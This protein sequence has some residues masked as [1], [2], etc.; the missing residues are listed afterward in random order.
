MRIISGSIVNYLKSWLGEDFDNNRPNMVF[1]AWTGFF[2]HPIYYFLC[3]KLLT[4]FED[5]LFFRFGSALLCLPVLLEKW[6]PSVLRPWLGIY[7]YCSIIFILPISFT[8]LLLLNNFSGMWLVCEVTMIFF[9]MIL[10][11]HFGLVFFILGVGIPLGYF[12]F[13]LYGGQNIIWGHQHLSYIVPIPVA[14]WSGVIFINNAQKSAIL[15]EKTKGFVALAGSIA[16]EMRN[17]L[18]QIKFSLD[19]IEH[20]LP[21]PTFQKGDQTLPNQHLNRLYSHL[22]Q[23]QVA[24]KR[25]L[26]VI[27]MTLNEV[28]GKPIAPESLE[29]LDA[30]KATQK[31]I[32]EY[33]FD[34]EGERKK[35]LLQVQSNFTF[36]VNETAYV[37]VLFNLIKNALYHLKSKPE[38]GITITVQGSRITVRDTGPGIAPDVL[39]KLFGNFVSTNTTG[40]TGLGLAYC[41]RTMQAFGGSIACDSVLGQYT[42]FTLQFPPL[43]PEAIDAYEQQVLHSAQAA[44]H[45]KRI[46]V[47]DDQDTMRKSTRAMLQGLD[48]QLD[49]AENGQL[50][51]EKLRHAPYDLIV[52]DLNMPPLDGYAAAEAIRQGAVPSQKNIPILAYTAE[53]AYVAHVKTQKVGMNGFVS[54]PCSRTELLKALY[55]A[56]EAAQANA[57]TVDLTVLQGKTIVV[58]DDEEANRKIVKAY[59]E[60]AGSLVLEATYG[61]DVLE[62]LEA[63]TRVHAVLMD[64]HMP[65]MGGVQVTRL[66]RA[67]NGRKHIP[68]IALTANFTDNHV[69]EALEAG[70]NDFIS[71]PIDKKQ[72]LEKLALLL[73]D[74]KHERPGTSNALYVVP[75]V[76][77]AAQPA[78]PAPTVAVP[79]DSAAQT[80][81][82]QQPT[83]PQT[84]ETATAGPGVMYPQRGSA[85]PPPNFPPWTPEQ[86]AHLQATAASG[87]ALLAVERLEDMRKI[88]LELMKEC[89]DGYTAK[90]VTQFASMRQQMASKQDFEG[91]SFTLHSMVGNAGEAGLHALHQYLR[92]RVYA[93]VAQDHQWP[94]EENWIDTAQDLYTQSMVAMKAT[95]LLGYV[96]PV[97]TA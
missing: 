28:G 35:V 68:V 84:T 64:M 1:S 61:T 14:L 80:E 81:V 38:A 88:D 27:A 23:G 9:T 70:M 77:I 25:G 6:L 11:G 32:E 86:L 54:K 30:A 34:T 82:A 7:W 58:A 37:F 16:H 46:L 13:F 91:F 4:G 41:Q 94:I 44:L 59:L 76:A 53:S 74:R 95:Y 51:I 36:K 5:S 52:M 69:Q 43:A 22:A 96:A 12:C 71:K 42:E 47:V 72:M 17:P 18:G 73:L 55:T 20:T 57:Q 3:T 56:V 45:G 2:A 97:E 87:L 85:P 92:Y 21:S 65:V 29:Y 26:Q 83:K 48:A 24:I 79:T 90:M 50:A 8:F 10:V 89:I 19:S 93:G 49:E 39:P 75:V 33:S 31:A 15:V 60:N 66:M 62:I 67:H 78:A 63:G 40:G